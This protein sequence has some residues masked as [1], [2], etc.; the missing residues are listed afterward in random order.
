MNPQ[1]AGLTVD[2]VKNRSLQASRSTCEHIF[3]LTRIK[4]VN[5]LD[6]GHSEMLMRKLLYQPSNNK[7]K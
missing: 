1:L 3:Q 4:T 6:A 7:A 5:T 2:G